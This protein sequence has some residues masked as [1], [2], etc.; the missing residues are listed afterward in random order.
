M[1]TLNYHAEV[2]L[3]ISL[4][5]DLKQAVTVSGATGGNYGN[6]VI[7]ITVTLTS[8]PMY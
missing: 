4:Q 6:A 1:V 7:N 5:P 3:N 2:V 8:D